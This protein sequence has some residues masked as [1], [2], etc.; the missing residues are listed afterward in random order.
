MQNL[1]NLLL[2][3][4]AACGATPHAAPRA[5][6]PPTEL[7]DAQRARDAA[8]APR[9]AAFVDAFTNE[10]PELLPDGRVV[11]SST[12]GGLPALYVADST[13]A[14]APPRKLPGPDDRM[15]GLR[16]LPGDKTA[17]FV[18]DHDADGNFHVFRVEL[19]GSG[20][21]DLTPSPV[22]HRDVPAIARDVPDVF[23]YS[24]HTM[25][26]PAAHLY[27]QK[28]GGAPRE[29]HV[30]KSAGYL[31]ELSPG[32]ER[33][34]LV[35]Y[36]SD[37][38]QILYSVDVA[39]GAATRLY[40]REDQVAAV[41]G[42]SFAPDGKSVYLGSE[43]RGRAA[44]VL[45]IDA[46]SGV[47]LAR[48]EETAAPH[49]SI[50]G[51]AVSPQ[52]DRIAVGIDAGDH[53]ELRLLDAALQHVRTAP[54]G[55]VSG[56]IGRFSAD[57][58]RL[59]ATLTRPDAPTDV[60]AI[61]TV[62]GEPAALRDD[63]RAG[64]TDAP[65]PRATIEHVA[66]FD[67]LSIPINVYLPPAV[68][69]RR[70]PTIVLVHGGPSGSAQIGWSYTIG[71]WTAMNFAVVAPNIRGSS[72]FGLDYM[73][74]DNAAK[75]GD[76]LRDME[77][78]N[79]WLRAQP[80]CDPDRLVIAGISYG[81]YMTLLALGMQPRSWAA[82]IDGSGMS[83]L[84]T[85]EELE[86]QTIRVFDETEFGTLGKDDAILAAWSPLSHVDAV[87]SPVF[88]YQGVKDPITPRD[89]ADQIVGALRRRGIPVEYML[90]AN[91]GHGITRRDNKIAYLVRS[92]RFLADHLGLARRA[93]F[94]EK[95]S[96]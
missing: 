53:T 60:F 96:E 78:I 62:T 7:D 25:T 32:G 74:A 2:A 85:M 39:S 55:L 1:R 21:S 76:A 42:P 66:A 72:G 36:V 84:K 51:I 40:P 52:G 31:V 44:L 24:A 9:A 64:L 5:E 65:K 43:A 38:S 93:P 28:L 90:I 22:M 86:D 15:F 73:A 69:T 3:G 35:T 47:E 49:A 23:A 95:P 83:N 70:L 68:T 54:L 48:Y 56:W 77:T 81:G 58:A 80:W 89:E 26:D 87:R 41:D 18:S 45:R 82:G 16:V 63:P 94:D 92:F 57:G 8:L 29:F 75:R 33:A 91:E 59:A 34:L 12:R 13:H 30:D 79:R 20:Y 67:G 71:F 4:V 37:E 50:S 88:V 17:L 6:A 46:A 14:G 61:D 19:D 11:Y 27:V 10:D